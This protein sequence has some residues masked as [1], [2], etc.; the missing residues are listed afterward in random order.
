MKTLI[1]LFIF[2][3][4]FQVNADTA[5]KVYSEKALQRYLSELSSMLAGRPLTTSEIALIDAKK[6]ASIKELLVA[7]TSGSYLPESARVMTQTQL[8]LSGTAG[9][10]NYNFPGDLAKYIVTNN[11]PYSQILTADYCINSAGAKVPCDTG[12]PYT[13]GVLTT[14]AYMMKSAGRFNL[15]RA[16]RLIMTFICR[17]YPLETG[18]QVPIEKPR[19]IPMFQ[20][21]IDGAGD[22]GNGT[23][24]YNCHSQ[25]GAHA[26]FFVK[27]DANG[28]YQ[29][30]ASGEQNP[31][32]EMGKSF[33]N[34]Y[35]S[36][37]SNPSERASETSQMFGQNVS[38]LREAAIVLTKSSLFLECAIRNT[39]RHVLRMSDSD[40]KDISGVLLGEISKKILV[41]SKDPSWKQ[42][43]IETFQHPGVIDSVLNAGGGQ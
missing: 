14:R 37:L 16:D 8:N 12:A 19:L 24:C 39:I 40:A 43:V 11:L 17:Q 34:L 30:G 5:P 21:N 1:A 3:A 7:W 33:N 28:V 25:F 42:I 2:V 15:N 4:S 6:T 41:T 18:L 27:F 20:V 22:F 23:S 36:H 29:A 13:A 32:V 9:G 31:A 26:Q 10:V 38:N 35:T